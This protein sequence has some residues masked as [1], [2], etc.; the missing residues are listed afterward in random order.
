MNISKLR[1][2]KLMMD[3]PVRMDAY[4]RAIEATC[5]GMTVCEIGVGLGPLSLMALRAGAER[6]YGVELDAE[7]LETATRVIRAS[8]F[9]PDRFIPIVGLSTQVVLPEQVDILLSETLD[10]MGIGE[11]TSRYMSDARERLL[12][13]GG[14]MLPARLDCYAAL[15]TP[16]A[17]QS[18][19]R[20]WTKGMEE[21]G[22]SYTPLMEQVRGVK[23][24]I[25]ITS[26]DLQSKWYCWQQNDFAAQK[27]SP[28]LATLALEVLTAGEVHGLAFAFDAVLSDGV[29]IRTFPGDPSTHWLQ[30]FAPFPQGPI[31]VGAGDLV[32]VELHFSQQ[33][34]PSL[35]W[36]LRVASGPVADV[37]S[38]MRERLAQMVADHS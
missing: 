13:P 8:G 19:C 35:I 4:H 2:Y 30:G 33:D 23:H 32:Y 29:N 37:A 1:N 9:G 12:K 15:S 14:V 5:P 6:V 27:G 10:S 24:T 17:Y 7:A 34:N 38:Y 20:F 31:Q 25:R 26:D 16:E 36:E 22:L 3:D 28:T 18:E 21:Y 11:N